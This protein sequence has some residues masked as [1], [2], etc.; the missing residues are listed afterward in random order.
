MK[1]ATATTTKY[2]ARRAVTAPDMRV[3]ARRT[4]TI[5]RIEKKSRNFQ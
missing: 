3:S 4:G 2:R 1:D 5:S